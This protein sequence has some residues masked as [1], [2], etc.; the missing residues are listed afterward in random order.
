MYSE[1]KQRRHSEC[2]FAL[3]EFSLVAMLLVLLVTGFL[4]SSFFFRGRS[5]YSTVA[6]L[7]ARD[8]SRASLE[9]DLTAPLAVCSRAWAVAESRDITPDDLLIGIAERGVGSDWVLCLDYNEDSGQ[10]ERENPAISII[11]QPKNSQPFSMYPWFEQSKWTVSTFVL[12]SESQL[13]FDS[14]MLTGDLIYVDGPNPENPVRIFRC[15]EP[16]EV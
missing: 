7:I 8:I 10:C 3:V 6:R 4:D 5:D 1:S 12:E 15:P 14:M 11:L 16:W 13:D 9:G 2:G